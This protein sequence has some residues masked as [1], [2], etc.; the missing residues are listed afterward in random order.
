MEE[1]CMSWTHLSDTRPRARKPY[2]CYLCARTIPAGDVHV[3]RTGRDEDGVSTARMHVACEARTR[4]WGEDEWE[5]HDPAEF[6]E[7]MEAGH[8]E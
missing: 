8:G 2:R 5:C 7:A 6:R 3:C 4:D 1:A